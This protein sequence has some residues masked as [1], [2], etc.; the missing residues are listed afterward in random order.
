MH[1]VLSAQSDCVKCDIEK[2]ITVS[3]NPGNLT[4]QMIDGFFCTFDDSC[5]MN[6][7][8]SQWSNEILFILLENEPEIVI[9]ILETCEIDTSKNVLNEIENP[10]QDF[11]Y[12]KIYEKVLETKTQG[13]LKVKILDSLVLAAEKEGIEIKK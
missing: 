5:K 9:K 13:N 10:V 8:F 11:D 6:V 4:F 1:P 7:E 3:E 12:Q 2:L